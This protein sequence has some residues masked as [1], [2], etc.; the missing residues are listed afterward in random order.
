VAVPPRDGGWPRL[1][2]RLAAP[3]T[4]ATLA[5]MFDQVL[6]SIA[7]LAVGLIV[8]RLGTKQEFGFYGLGYTAIIVAN[9]FAG[10]LFAGQMTVSYYGV[11]P[12]ERSAFAGALFLAQAVLSNNEST[13]LN[14][15]LQ[16]VTWMLVG[17]SLVSPIRQDTTKLLRRAAPPSVTWPPILRKRAAGSRSFPV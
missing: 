17:L 10:A 1:K 11:A 3:G 12:A 7:N 2:A 4:I 13:L 14:V 16:F 8:L 5:G 15:D 9:S 6:I